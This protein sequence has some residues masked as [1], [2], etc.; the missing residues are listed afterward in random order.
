MVATVKLNIDPQVKKEL[1]ELAAFKDKDHYKKT[2]KDQVTN[3]P[4]EVQD[5]R[6]AAL[7]GMI[8]S[9]NHKGYLFWRPMLP[10]SLENKVIKFV[11]L[12]LGH[13]GS[14]KCIVEIAHIFYVKNFGRKARKILSC[15]DV[16]QRVKHSN[17]S[18]EIESRIHLPKKPGNLCALDFYAQL[19]AGRGGVGTF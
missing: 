19:P 9:K 11:H 15:C 14:E 18:Y 13:A 8:H 5:G 4:A 17:R 7:D 2:L 6:Y 3:Q 16:C 10:S 12:S 1:K